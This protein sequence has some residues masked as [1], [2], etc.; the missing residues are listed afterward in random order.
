M[1]TSRL[2]GQF[3][4]AAL[5]ALLLGKA[6]EATQRSIELNVTEASWL[7][8][9]AVEPVDLVTIV[10]N[11]VDNAMDAATA[12]PDPRR[13]EVSIEPQCDRVVVTV[14][15]S[16]PGFSPEAL[17]HVFEPGWS[18]KVAGPDRRHGRGIGMALV[19]QVVARLGGAVEVANSEPDHDLPGAIVTV[20]LP[21][22][23]TAREI[24]EVREGAQAGTP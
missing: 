1:L 20:H 11:L 9:D 19:R 23:S 4:E 17:A 13:V 18:T 21:M 15:D 14:R 12:R 6:S 24:V 22:S 7:P 5:V 16:G 3:E 8:E 10:G 2:S